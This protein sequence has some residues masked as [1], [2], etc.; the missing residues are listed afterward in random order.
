M[1]RGRREILVSCYGNDRKVL[2]K[3]FEGN[4]LGKKSP[5]GL[6]SKSPE[7]SFVWKCVDTLHFKTRKSVVG[8]LALPSSPSKEG[9]EGMGEKNSS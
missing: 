7:S 2:C 5:S 1:A 8:K 9:E 6:R 3:T 4:F